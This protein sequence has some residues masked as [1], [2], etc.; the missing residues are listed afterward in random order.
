MSTTIIRLFESQE[1]AMNAV[2]ALRKRFDDDAITVVSPAKRPPAVQGR[3]EA[4]AVDNAFEPLKAAGLS[5]AAATK[6]AEEVRRGRTAVVVRAPFGFAKGAAETLDEF[7][8]VLADIRDET[9]SLDDDPAPLSEALGLPLLSNNPAPLSLMFGLRVLSRN[10]DSRIKLMS[11]P[12]PL[13]NVFR[14]P[15][16][17]RGLESRTRSFGLPLLSSNPAPLSSLLGLK[18][19]SNEP[20]PLSSALGLPELSDNPTPLSSLFGLPVLLPD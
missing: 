12:A 15:L 13:S 17:S 18:L 8:P 1:K 4:P 10:Q 19:L 3:P 9:R 5:T 14:L 2:A 6:C 20:A 11:N 16:L 7:A